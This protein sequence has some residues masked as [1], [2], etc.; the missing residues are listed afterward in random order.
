MPNIHAPTVLRW[1]DCC[2]VPVGKATKRDFPYEP[3]VDSCGFG[4]LHCADLCAR[5]PVGRGQVEGDAQNVVKIIS[6]DKLKTQTYC[7]IVELEDEIDEAQGSSKAEELSQKVDQ[8]VEKL[9]PEYI[10]L[11]SKL[12]D[13]DPNSQDGQEIGSII[14]RLDD[15]CGD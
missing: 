11:V 1:H 2:W 5:S 12:K 10:A 3:V 7:E 9:G 13:I 6:G 8:L 15:L 14:G 4:N